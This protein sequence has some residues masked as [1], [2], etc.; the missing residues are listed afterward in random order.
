MTEFNIKLSHHFNL[1]RQFLSGQLEFTKFE[2]DFVITWNEFNE[3]YE[4]K[5]PEH[6]EKVLQVLE[7]R[8]LIYAALD[9]CTTRMRPRRDLGELSVGE[10]QDLL[11]DYYREFLK[12][13]FFFI[14]GGELN[15]Q[16]A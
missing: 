9:C 8:N 14:S 7:I 5:I 1:V 15:S 16:S 2:R 11:S 6:N 4:F 10:F 12:I 3:K 13:K